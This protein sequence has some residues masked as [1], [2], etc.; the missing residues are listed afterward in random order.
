MDMKE[1]AYQQKLNKNAD[2]MLKK[3]D[4]GVVK[5]LKDYQSIED[6]IQKTVTSAGEEHLKVEQQ[7]ND[8]VVPRTQAEKEAIDAQKA[9]DDGQLQAD[10]IRLKYAQLRY[11]LEEKLS[12]LTPESTLYDQA[13]EDMKK[14]SAAMDQALD[15]NMRLT[16]ARVT[17]VHEEAYNK[18]IDTVKQGAGQVFDA[19]LT[20]GKGA[21]QSLSDWIEGFFMTRLKQLFE[22]LVAYVMGGFKGGF[23]SLLQGVLPS[24]GGG[25]PGMI[26]GTSIGNFVGPIQPGG[27]NLAGI[28]PALGSR[29]WAAGCWAIRSGA[30]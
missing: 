16:S 21:F 24:F 15:D 9:A 12:H 19:M 25:S 8:A 18:M 23:A 17:K 27:F 7:I 30:A 10:A 11:E 4:E 14:L 5:Q 20:K 3:W 13:V 22:N 29:A 2:E 28:M 6:Q 1:D 26:G